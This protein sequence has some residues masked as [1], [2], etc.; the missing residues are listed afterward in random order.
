MCHRLKESHH[1]HVCRRDVGAYFRPPA[2]T[3]LSSNISYCLEAA[4]S[5]MRSN[6]LQPNP[7]KTEVLW[8]ATVRRQRQ[9]STSPPLIDACSITPVPFIRDP[10]VYIDCDL[11]MLTHVQRTVSRCFASLRQLPKMRRA[12]PSTTPQMSMV[13]LVHP[14]RRLVYRNAVLVGLSV[15]LMRQLQSVLNAAARLNLPSENLRPHN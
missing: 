15:Y 14:R 4:T 5:W 7:D 9:L 1:T 8:C 13:A 10:G 6:R 2:V 11:S 12:V 3:A